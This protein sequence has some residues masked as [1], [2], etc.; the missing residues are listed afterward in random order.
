M[1]PS[2]ASAQSANPA[3]NTALRQRARS[4]TVV[5]AV[6]LIASPRRLEHDDE[7]ILG[8]LREAQALARERFDSGVLR[9]GAL[10]D[11]QS[12]PID[13]QLVELAI[14]LL[15]FDEQLPRAMLDAHDPDS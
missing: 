2:S 7:L 12:T 1:R 15:T 5:F 9:P 11:L 10:L 8:G 13:L 6:R 4:A 3:S 14:Q